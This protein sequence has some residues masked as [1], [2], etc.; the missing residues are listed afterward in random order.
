LV[1]AEVDVMSAQTV[2]Y[3]GRNSFAPGTVPGRVGRL[4]R[5]AITVCGFGSPADAVTAA[6]VAFH[7]LRT[8]LEMRS[9]RAFGKLGAA[10][11]ATAVSVRAE[12]DSRAEPFCFEL[13]FP[14]RLT[15]AKAVRAARTITNA[16]RRWA[17]DSLER[18]GDT[19]AGDRAATG[20]KRDDVGD[21]SVHSFPASDPPGWIPMWAGAP[22]INTE[23]HE[24]VV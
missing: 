6:S 5:D 8:E 23:H 9:G 21:D 15:A 2:F 12:A 11:H 24:E 18:T 19:S 17:T 3:H 4:S 10:H 7:A 22:T 16:L 13:Q 14:V 20:Q 1:E